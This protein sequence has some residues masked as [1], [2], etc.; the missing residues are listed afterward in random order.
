MTLRPTKTRTAGKR[1]AGGPAAKRSSG[2]KPVWSRS[3][4]SAETIQLGRQL[5]ALRMRRGWS[6]A[7]VSRMSGIS[8]S[9]LSRIENN[10]LSPTM[11]IVSG[12]L[13]GLQI[14]YHEL[15]MPHHSRESAGFSLVTR[16]G[17][18]EHLSFPG[19]AYEIL[20][21]Q[22]GP[23]PLHAT[24][25]T[26]G[27]RTAEEM[28]GLSGHEGEEFLYVLAGEIELHRYGFEVCVLQAGDSIHFDSGPPHVYLARSRQPARVLVVTN[29]RP[30]NGSKVLEGPGRL[31]APHRSER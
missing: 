28:G 17:N 15:I 1:R 11:D 25:L 16:R 19:F 10:K 7:D 8:M 26:V 22:S 9:T 21:T 27:A 29:S 14:P 24:I 4:R 12:L 23:S 2:T 3:D 31:S 13:N 6:L 18:G 20:S 30:Q 5:Q